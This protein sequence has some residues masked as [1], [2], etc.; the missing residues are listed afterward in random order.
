MLYR[1][2]D[3]DFRELRNGE[4]R[5]NRDLR[6]LVISGRMPGPGLYHPGPGINLCGLK[7]R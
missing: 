6:T 2:L 1:I 7:R 5:R 3:T 4:V